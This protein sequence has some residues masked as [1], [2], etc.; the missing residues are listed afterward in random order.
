MKTAEQ[1]RIKTRKGIE[2]IIKR[3]FKKINYEIKE[4]ARKGEYYC[5]VNLWRNFDKD[6]KE[7]ITQYYISKGYNVN[8]RM[9]DYIKMDWKKKNE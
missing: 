9:D 8:F 5:Y 7:K 2:R 4:T 6:E 3:T 1:M